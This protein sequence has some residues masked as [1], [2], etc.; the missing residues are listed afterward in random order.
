MTAT[1]GMDNRSFTP[2]QMKNALSHSRATR[3][4]EA[5]LQHPAWTW[6]AAQ[7]QFWLLN[8]RDDRIA[9]ARALAFAVRAHDDLAR[10]GEASYLALV[11][12]L[13]RH[14]AHDEWGDAI[15]WARAADRPVDLAVELSKDVPVQIRDPELRLESF[16]PHVRPALRAAIKSDLQ[17]R[18]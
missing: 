2:E 5:I 10:S 1:E 14:V 3:A 4:M 6:V 15:A 16:P 7:S 12:H 9:L 8:H 18:E 13:R 11:P 17:K